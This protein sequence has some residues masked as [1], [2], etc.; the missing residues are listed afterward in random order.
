MKNLFQLTGALLLAIML[1]AC[2]GPS[3][4]TDGGDGET[5][6]DGLTV[7]TGVN[8]ALF[9]LGSNQE[10]VNLDTSE[11]GIVQV[12]LLDENQQAIENREVTIAVS[13]SATLSINDSSDSGTLSVNDL[14]NEN[15]Y[16]YAYLNHIRLAST[17]DPVI[18]NITISVEGEEDTV[19]DYK[20]TPEA[21]PTISLNLT[22]KISGNETTRVE[23][24]DTL[25]IEATLLDGQGNPV[26][27]QEVSFAIVS[28]SATLNQLSDLTGSD[29]ST[30]PIEVNI[31]SLTAGT[32]EVGRIV[33][34]ADDFD[35]QTRI[36]QFYS[37][38]STTNQPLIVPS[39]TLN[40]V[41]TNRFLTSET[42]NVS[43][44]LTDAQG[45]PVA[46][47]IVSFAVSFGTGVLSQESALTNSGGEV[48]IDLSHGGLAPN[49]T[50]PGVI[51]ISA[52][53][54]DEKS[55]VYEFV[56]AGAV[57]TAKP[58]LNIIMAL[59]SDD[60]VT[61]RIPVTDTANVTGLLLDENN[62]PI[63]DEFVSVSSSNG[64]LS[65][66][67]FLTNSSGEFE[68]TLTP[69][70]SLTQGTA[71]GLLSFTVESGLVELQTKVYEFVASDNVEPEDTSSVGSI[72]FLSADPQIIS[73]KGTGGA[74]FGEVS[75]VKFLVNDTTGNPIS[76]VRVFFNLTTTVGELS[77]E[78]DSAITGTDGVAT[79]FVKSGTIA[80]PVRVTASVTLSDGTPIFTQS[81]QL[82]LTTGIPDSNSISLSIE[83]FSP[84]AWLEDG[85]EVQV[86]M[87]VADRFNNPVPD[88]TVVNF[89]TEGGSIEGSCQTSGFPV[90]SGCSVTWTSQEPRPKDRR[91]TILATVVGHETYYDKNGS[92]EF[93][94]A[95]NSPNSGD[96]LDDG[97]EDLAEAF[98]D[99]DEN[100][101]YDP[102]ASVVSQDEK[103]IDYDGDGEYS[104][105]DGL[106][107]GS[108]CNFPS[109]CAPDAN[110]L[111]GASFRL[112]T[113][114]QSA[115]I[116][117]P[118]STPQ[119]FIRELKIGGS[120]LDNNGK[121]LGEPFCSD[122]LS[123][124]EFAE[125]LDTK[126]LWVLVQD[127]V[128][129]CLDSSGNRI[130]IDPIIEPIEKDRYVANTEDSSCALVTRQSAATGSSI[131][132]AF[133]D[134][135]VEADRNPE[136]VDNDIFW[137]EF[138][139]DVSSDDENR[140]NVTGKFEVSVTVPSG[141][142]T[143]VTASILDPK[144]PTSFVDSNESLQIEQN[145]RIDN[146]NLL[147]NLT[148]EDSDS[149]SVTG[150]TISGDVDVNGDPTEYSVN[151]LV[152]LNEIDNSDPNAP[153]EVKIGDIIMYSDGSFIYT[154]VSGF[155]GFVPVIAYTIV[156]DNDAEDTGSSRLAITYIEPEN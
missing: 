124:I 132:T 43:A 30:D 122:P 8:A 96:S 2:G 76:G 38:T 123:P 107:N 103:F 87:R 113:L 92:G 80:T 47:E 25:L 50:E 79:A 28:G 20:F 72:S 23:D 75:Q 89:T 15:G 74:G 41:S 31:A 57:T 125:G 131:A 6:S 105:P 137:D 83:T 100:G 150:F 48:S 98:R 154:P 69:P 97:F 7:E 120:C 62:A 145:I 32:E 66:N 146:V 82:T 139:V 45:N 141:V 19:L 129:K 94:D 135:N 17:D 14:T 143:T 44:L 110:N 51:N 91:V 95:A 151:T 136:V 11:T 86:N 81:D 65:Q 106:W 153:V 29:G 35:A 116:T 36:F 33:I 101:I 121:I 16:V 13:G 108:P 93:D 71:P 26:V 1:G 77:L 61:N 115:V 10:T 73:L 84:E 90:A 5:P 68:F 88:G 144:D 134:L 46:D 147:A 59:T 148:D 109:L 67:R 60:T 128:G 118:S 138:T 133:E 42:A 70:D 155:L 39:I 12:V 34:T 22:S 130:P 3:G 4:G 85:L 112:T 140:E 114:S 56:S 52:D 78:S 111:A 9:V 55:L 104:D 142:E 117:I 54:F 40:G 119:I 53:G 152:D 102:N 49:T 99:D 18:G 64:S 21:P 149:H 27:G 24:S 63:A 37:D 127:Q 156:D 126:T 58:S